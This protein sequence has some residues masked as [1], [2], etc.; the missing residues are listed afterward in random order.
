M[1]LIYSTTVD[2]IGKCAEE[3]LEH[4]MF[5]V[6]KNNAPQELEDY[7]YIHSENNLVKNIQKGDC[8]YIDESEYKIMAVGDVVNQNLRDLGHITFKFSGSE[9]A[10]VQGTLYLENKKIA[11]L[12]QGTIIKIIR[13]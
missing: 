4:N 10:S 8:L 2:K 1:E 9:D 3:F 13:N 6:F 7:C 11:P 12:G 5:I